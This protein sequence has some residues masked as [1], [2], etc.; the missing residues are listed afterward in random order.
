MTQIQTKPPNDIDIQI[1]Q[2]GTHSAK[3]GALAPTF[4]KS[5]TEPKPKPKPNLP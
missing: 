2:Q 3:I 1:F 5:A 4:E